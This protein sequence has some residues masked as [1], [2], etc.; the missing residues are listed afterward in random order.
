MK[1]LCLLLLALVAGRLNAAMNIR[2]PFYVA[3]LK[4]SGLSV[5]NFS[6]TN[7]GTAIAWWVGDN[8]TLT[9]SSNAV[10][11]WP[12]SFS[13]FNL[14]N[15]NRYQFAPKALTNSLN[16]HHTIKF[17]G[18]SPSNW[19][20]NG[21]WTN[22]AQAEYAIVMKWPTGQTGPVFDS[23]NGTAGTIHRFTT[24]LSGAQQAALYAGNVG[25]GNTWTDALTNKW[26]VYFCVFDGG[27]SRILTNNLQYANAFNSGGGFGTQIVFG[28][29]RTS[30]GFNA[31]E[32]AEVCCFYG[33]NTG[34]NRTAIYSGLTNKY[35][36][37][38]FRP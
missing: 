33:T 38:N 30:S 7:F 20:E 8:A 1:A 6:P 36:N 17:T 22:G 19:L 15:G 24:Q 26:I 27:T 35:G 12:D 31:Y 16:G 18:N 23:R 10:A 28:T 21:G 37:T 2:D 32:I 11:T 3:S 5:S 34:A 4:G 25:F 14:T 13:S 29:D 9:G